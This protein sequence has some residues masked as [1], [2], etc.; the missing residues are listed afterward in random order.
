M[1]GGRGEWRCEKRLRV[2]LEFEA[3]KKFFEFSL[4][5]QPGEVLPLEGDDED[6][7]ARIE[8]KSLRVVAEAEAGDEGCGLARGAIDG[9]TDSP[10][11]P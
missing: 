1:P 2:S 5:W 4:E 8:E 7:D 11:D 6:D 9:A 3:I 10:G